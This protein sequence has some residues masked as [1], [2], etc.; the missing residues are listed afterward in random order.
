MGV[1]P[2]AGVSDKADE[3]ELENLM[4]A[5]EA[6]ID[7]SE[8]GALKVSE[9][10]G[11]EAADVQVGCIGA[12]CVAVLPGEVGDG[13]DDEVVHGQRGYRKGRPGRTYLVDVV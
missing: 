13:R 9:L 10:G 3:V 5:G 6:P 7:G 1:E 8:K 12:E 11:S 4:S 2:V